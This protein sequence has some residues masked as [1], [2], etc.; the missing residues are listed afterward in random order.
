MFQCGAV[1]ELLATSSDPLP[2]SFALLLAMAAQRQDRD[3]PNAIVVWSDPA[4]DYTR[5]R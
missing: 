1:Q 4:T 3:E 5:R 2:V